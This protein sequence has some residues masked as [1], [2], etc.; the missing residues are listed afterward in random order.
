[1]ELG[2]LI[3]Y[4]ASNIFLQKSRIKSGREISC[5]PVFSKKTLYKVKA[6]GQQLSFNIFW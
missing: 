2:L 5:R 6:S 4:S 3:K 1:M